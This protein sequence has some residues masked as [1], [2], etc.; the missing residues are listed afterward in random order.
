MEKSNLIASVLFLLALLVG[1][2]VVGFWLF[3]S[4]LQPFA[5]A[6]VIGI[7]FYP[8]YL[9]IS[10][11]VRGPNKSALLATFAALLTFVLP[12]LLIASAAGGELIKA[13]R[14]L[15]DRS[16]QEG[17]AITYLDHKQQSV[18]RWLEKYVDV[19]ELR[20]EDAMANLPGQVSKFL[21]AAGTGLVG[22]LAGFAGNAILTFLILFF[23]F[24][25]GN[26]A[27]ENFTSILPLSRDQAVRL[28]TGIR[29]SVV[30]NLYGILAVGLAQG[31]LTGA[32]LAIL[33]VPSALLLGL[34]AAVCS[35]IP[36]VG[37]ML[38]W[39]PAAIYLMAIG[40]LWKGIFLILWGALV[41]GTVDN[42]IRPLVIGSKIELHPLVLLFALL[43]GLQ[44]FGFIGIFIGPVVISL[45][46]VLI[47]MLREEL[48]AS[49]N[50]PSSTASI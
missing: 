50:A 8:L 2:V 1:V 9:R 31:L 38:V 24:R 46:A 32:A 48:T 29:D 6:I 39:L 19:E 11:I 23:V 28:L 49:R 33:R 5:F 21:L 20:L 45:I 26:T 25:D 12:T 15:G 17:G 40:H 22:G 27:I 34:T 3:R 43:G 36:I 44:A 14:Y 7:G 13:A 35:L 47:S 10:R 30:A 16:T 37:T 18:L 41:V 4:F 42:V